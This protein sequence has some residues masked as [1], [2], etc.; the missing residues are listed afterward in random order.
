MIKRTQSFSAPVPGYKRQVPKIVQANT[1]L[2]QEFLQGCQ[3]VL[4]SRKM[5]FINL[6]TLSNKDKKYNIYT[7]SMVTITIKSIVLKP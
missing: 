1:E 6:Y 2:L 7:N 5:F 4:E 3:S